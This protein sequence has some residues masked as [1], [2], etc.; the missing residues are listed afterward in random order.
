ML[1]GKRTKI[2]YSMMPETIILGTV[3]CQGAVLVLRHNC[4]VRAIGKP[5]ARTGMVKSTGAARFAGNVTRQYLQCGGGQRSPSCGVNMNV[6]DEPASIQGAV[7]GD[8][9]RKRAVEI[10]C[11]N[12][13]QHPRSY[14]V[15]SSWV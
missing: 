4:G 5:K 13:H 15:D 14:W 10:H 8:I 2:H 12:F 11:G 9:V 3:V 7:H 1:C 6:S